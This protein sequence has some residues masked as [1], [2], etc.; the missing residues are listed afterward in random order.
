MPNQA[1]G[2]DA[3]RRIFFVIVHTAC[4]TSLIDPGAEYKTA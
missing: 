2:A 1:I 3:A 4:F